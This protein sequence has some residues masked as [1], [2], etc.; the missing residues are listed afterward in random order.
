VTIYNKVTDA[1]T[2]GI[3]TPKEAREL[4]DL[5]YPDSDTCFRACL[6][7]MD[8]KGDCAITRNLTSTHRAPNWPDCNCGFDAVRRVIVRLSEV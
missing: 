7:Y 8:H 6:Q 2:L 3:V 5:P 1:D 4:F